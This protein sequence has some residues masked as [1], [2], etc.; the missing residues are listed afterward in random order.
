[1]ATIESDH[2]EK[3]G[4]VNKDLLKRVV[5]YLRHSIRPRGLS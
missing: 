1:L 2:A 4:R 5:A 3:I